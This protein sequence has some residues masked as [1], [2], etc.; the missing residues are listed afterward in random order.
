[1][2]LFRN[3]GVIDPMSFTTFGLTSKAGQEKIGRF[4]TGLKYALASI[5]R[6][7]GSVKIHSGGEE[8]SF[9]KHD[10]KFRDSE[11]QQIMMNGEPLPYTE[12]LGRDWKPWMAFRELYSNALDEDGYLERTDGDI[13]EDE[14]ETII[15]VDYNAFEAIY[16]SIEEHFIVDEE[17]IWENSSLEIYKGQAKFVFYKGIAVMEL[18]EPASYRY[19][20]KGYVSLTEDRTV[21]YRWMVEEKI[22]EALLTVDNE[23]IASQVT[24]AS[25][26]FEGKL[27]YK[28]PEAKPSAMFLG[29]AAKNGVSCSPSASTVV[30]IYTPDADRNTTT[31]ISPERPGGACL[32]N[33]LSILRWLNQDLSEVRWVLDPSTRLAHSNWIVRNGTIMICNS[34]FD[35]QDEMDM[36]VVEAWEKIKG[37]GWLVKVI[38]KLS[39]QEKN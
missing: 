22:A 1:M 13:R 28:K 11:H 7:G 24:K 19:N 35:D 33:S 26:P 5:L 4:G 37:Q 3:P 34:I 27:D 30:E 16:F 6:D 38:K 23:E 32:L 21:Q 39:E 14:S 9:T 17:P 29:A 31:I 18:P 36:A 8:Y 20:L 10:L 15:A 12:S 25:R 2:I